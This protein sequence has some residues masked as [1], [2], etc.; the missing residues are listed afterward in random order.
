VTLPSIALIGFGEVGQ[1]LAADLQ[2][3][4]IDDLIAWDRLFTD[5]QSPPAR[6]ARSAGIAAAHGLRAA[7]AGRDIVVSAVTAAECVAV[8]AEAAPALR[9]DAFFVDL[10]S[11]APSSRSAAATV[12]GKVGGR[13]VELAVMSPI[14]PRRS[15][16]S[17]SATCSMRC[18]RRHRLPPPRC[19][20][21]P[22]DHRLPRPLHHRPS[23][24]S[25]LP[26]RT[27]R[28]HQ[29]SRRTAGEAC[30]GDR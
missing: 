26:R 12:I 11:A 30:A 10:N 19:E 13:Y 3:R 4:G 1:T 21:P 5:P 29:G 27:D 28:R 8:A 15:A 20:A 2:A 24:P 25:A 6:A 16:K 22:H 7:V 17:S 18:S 9:Q 23:G 14:A